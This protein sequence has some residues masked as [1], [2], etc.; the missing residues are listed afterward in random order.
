[1]LPILKNIEPFSVFLGYEKL[2]NSS[3]S[4]SIV[5]VIVSF[6]KI[7][8]IFFTGIKI[9]YYKGHGNA[10][11][12]C[13]RPYLLSNNLLNFPG[14]DLPNIISKNRINYLTNKEVIINAKI[15]IANVI[16]FYL[17]VKNSGLSLKGKFALA[18]SLM[19]Y[20]G[21]DNFKKDIL[22]TLKSIDVV[23]CND[24]ASPFVRNFINL[25]RESHCHVK[26][27]CE[28]R[29]DIF[30]IE[31][32]DFYGYDVYSLKDQQ[33]DLK[34]YCGINSKIL[35]QNFSTKKIN[36]SN[37]IFE[38]R[39]LFLQ[40]YY[41]P[42]AFKSRFR[43]FCNNIGVATRPMVLTRL[44]PNE[45]FPEIFIF[46]IMHVIGIISVSDNTLN[47][48]VERC[49]FSISF[50]STALEYFYN[51]THRPCKYISKKNCGIFDNSVTK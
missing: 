9:F 2:Q 34:K 50:S 33:K 40:Q 49:K 48:D 15:S 4:S 20:I 51:V 30:S 27:I 37:S 44:H 8:M 39:L 12:V 17:Y 7:F 32:L 29:L 1:M 3:F 42:L 35:V 18:S 6:A 43:H 31:W 11:I 21:C 45:R 46:K 16:D 28:T 24:P 41:H 13:D 25:S 38:Y 36:S 14:S 19:T 22:H 47:E 26:L 5:H 10:M 23:L